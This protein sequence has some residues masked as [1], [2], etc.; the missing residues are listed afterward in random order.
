MKIEQF[1]APFD[2]YGDY[3]Y[4]GHSNPHIVSHHNNGYQGYL[5]YTNYHIGDYYPGDHLDELYENDFYPHESHDSFS[6]YNSNH[7]HTDTESFHDSLSD[8]GTSAL[9]SHSLNSEDSFDNYDNGSYDSYHSSD[10]HFRNFD[11]DGIFSS[12]GSSDDADYDHSND[13]SQSFLGSL[14]SLGSEIEVFNYYSNAS[15]ID[16]YTDGSSS[17]DS[18]SRSNFGGYRG[19][20]GHGDQDPRYYLGYHGYGPYG[21]YGFGPY[22]KYDPYFDYGYA[23]DYDYYD[24]EYGKVDDYTYVG[25]TPG[26]VIDQ[27]V[28]NIPAQHAYHVA[29]Q[30]YNYPRVY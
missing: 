25:P 16:A 8:E 23:L 3:I 10:Y 1:G 27:F 26:I 2:R 28:S 30:Y 20:Q 21:D 19:R 29:D 15:E 22:E 24:N 4:D 13:A 7:L 6:E 11:S 17:I 12:L 5:A 9:Y 18:F 14:S